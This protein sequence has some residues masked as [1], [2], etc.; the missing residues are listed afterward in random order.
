MKLTE[1]DK[2]VSPEVQAWIKTWDVT[3]QTPVH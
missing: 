3:V 1:L 2:Q